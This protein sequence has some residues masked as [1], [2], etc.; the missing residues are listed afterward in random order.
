[1]RTV[2]L[3][4]LPVQGRR[5][6]EAELESKQPRNGS[7]RKK[8]QMRTVQLKILPVQ[9]HRNAEAELE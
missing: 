1:M 2:Q 4:I 8:F 5:N 9:G 3:K 6:A 7:A